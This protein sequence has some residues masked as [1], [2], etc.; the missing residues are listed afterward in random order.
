MWLQVASTARS[1][2]R[3][4]ATLERCKELTCAI[5]DLLMTYA[6][7]AGRRLTLL[8]Q[9]VVLRGKKIILIVVPQVLPVDHDHR[10]L[11]GE[12]EA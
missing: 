8:L 10:Q 1:D 11:A 4:E 5:C 6:L 2:S 9:E 7:H 3:T 12:I